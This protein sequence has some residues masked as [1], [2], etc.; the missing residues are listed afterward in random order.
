M[1]RLQASARQATA[2][3]NL[4][5]QTGQAPVSARGLR[6]R[7]ALVRAAR[8]VFERDGFRKARILDICAEAGIATGSFYTYFK[9]KEDAFAAVMA[10][11]HEET[12]HPRLN[13]I[14]GS[15]DPRAVIDA[16][17]YGIDMWFD[18][19]AEMLLQLWTTALQIPS[20][21]LRAAGAAPMTHLGAHL[22]TPAPSCPAERYLYEGLALVAQPE[23][24]IAQRL[25]MTAGARGVTEPGRRPRAAH[26]P[27]Q[28][29]PPHRCARSPVCIRTT[30]PRATDDVP[31]ADSPTR[32]GSTK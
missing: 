30:T 14:A 29:L 15:D 4:P 11:V 28:V 26:E 31:P 17:V 23:E 32:P 12:F 10:E 24:A 25:A 1:P 21:S 8:A 3:Q 9:T 18:A 27:R 16:F 2:A 13:A 7:V 19:L 5:S 6:S 22:E 20:D